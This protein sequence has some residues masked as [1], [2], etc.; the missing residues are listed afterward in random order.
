[1]GHRNFIVAVAVAL[2]ASG[3]Q[4][5]AESCP[6]S[7]AVLRYEDGRLFRAN[8]YAAARV[9]LEQVDFC[10]PH[11]GYEASVIRGTM[12]GRTAYLWTDVMSGMSGGWW[13]SSRTLPR[14]NLKRGLVPLNWRAR[15]PDADCFGLKGTTMQEGPAAGT[16]QEVRCAGR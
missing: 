8:G 5:N 16:I 14:L 15:A 10:R 9:K 13:S 6:I 2:T 1:M 11:C 12:K 3:A 7:R 4:A